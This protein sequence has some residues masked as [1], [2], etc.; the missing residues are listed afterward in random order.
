MFPSYA[1]LLSSLD[2]V[3]LSSRHHICSSD[4]SRRKI[5]A[6]ASHPQLLSPALQLYEMFIPRFGIRVRGATVLPFPSN[7]F[8]ALSHRKKNRW[9][10]SLDSVVAR[11]G[12]V[13][14]SACRV[15]TPP[16]V[17]INEITWSTTDLAG[18]AVFKRGEISTFHCTRPS[19][20]ATDTQ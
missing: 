16:A 2:L 15:E 8:S 12:R 11:T 3:S 10:F 20:Q 17:K 9:V 14:M 18:S 19:M 4:L 7:F 5:C 6:L 1:L 13:V